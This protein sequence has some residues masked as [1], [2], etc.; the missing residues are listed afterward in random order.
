M[1][2]LKQFFL[3]V[4]LFLSQAVFLY[5]AITAAASASGSSHAAA[6][7]QTIDLQQVEALA[8]FYAEESV[9]RLNIPLAFRLVTLLSG[10]KVSREDELAKIR[11]NPPHATD[12]NVVYPFGPKNPLSLA[13][14]ADQQ[15]MTVWERVIRYRRKIGF[16]GFTG[17]ELA[18]ALNEVSDDSARGG[19][20]FGF[21]HLDDSVSL[22]RQYSTSPSDLTQFYKEVD[23]M[24]ET[25]SRWS[26]SSDKFVKLAKSAARRHA[27]VQSAVASQEGFR[28]TLTLR[29][30]SV[31]SPLIKGYID[32]YARIWE[33]PYDRPAPLL[34]SDR[35][36]QAGQGLAAF[37]HFKGAGVNQ[38]GLASLE[39]N[40]GL[41][42]PD[43]HA[44]FE[45][46]IIPLWH[47][48]GPPATH[49]QLGRNNMLGHLGSELKLGQYTLRANVCDLAADRCVMLATPFELVAN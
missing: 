46:N 38:K 8:L 41:I 45:D 10:D 32:D 29:H 19:G 12:E 35:V 25:N 9:R 3:Q 15:T 48:A 26:N 20:T 43:G 17:P 13:F 37:I 23:R 22:F 18:E 44:I 30:F 47:E 39:A 5:L 7:N 27:P 21:N 49:L 24:V 16:Y 11:A 4:R 33:R 34:V 36:A 40:F 14:D 2:Y 1:C 6:D 42:G 31:S 28:A